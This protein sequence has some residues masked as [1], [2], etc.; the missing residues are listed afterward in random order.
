MALQLG[1]RPDSWSEG[2]E[3]EDEF[4]LGVELKLELELVG[5]WS[6]RATESTKAVAQIKT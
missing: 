3:F 1:E 4:E 5:G 6:P 2:L